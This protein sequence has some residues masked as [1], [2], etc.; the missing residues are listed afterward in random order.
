MGLNSLTYWL[1]S[2]INNHL[3]KCGLFSDLQHGLRSSGSTADLLTVVS[4]R[5]ARVFN[6]SGVTQAVTL[7]IP[8]LLTL[9]GMLVFFTNLGLLE[10]WVR[11]AALFLLFSVID[12]FKWF[13]M[14]SLFKN[15][16]L[17][18]EFLKVSFLVSHFS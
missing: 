16:Q 14:G 5:I 11:Y 3:E 9:F 2:S 13:W 15:I 10:F 6:T 8:K 7:D 17:M 4:D 18:L 12:G 1:N